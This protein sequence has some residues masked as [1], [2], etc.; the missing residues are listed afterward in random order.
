MTDISAE[1]P[2]GK[3]LG[4]GLSRTGTR[5]LQAAL[6]ELGYA[7]AHFVEHRDELRGL[8]TWFQGNFSC[9]SLA[10]YDAATDLPIPIFYQQLDRRYPGSKFVLTV[11][12]TGEWLT[13]VRKLWRRREIKDDPPGRYRRL[14]RQSMFGT[15]EFSE[16]QLKLVHE[17]HVQDVTGYFQGRNDDL[18][19]LSICQGEGWEKL[20]PFLGKP[21]PSTRFPWHNRNR[22]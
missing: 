19:T 4:V 5:S 6:T 9:D 7:T 12:D 15:C 21:V 3:I 13:S 8:N 14:V 10:D 17:K 2:M 1:L 16:E 18:L 11:R 22:E 20:C